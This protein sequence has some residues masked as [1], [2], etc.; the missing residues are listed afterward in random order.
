MFDFLATVSPGREVAWDCATGSGQAAIGLAGYFDR[1]IATDASAAQIDEAEAHPRIEYRVAPAHESGIESASIDL[2]T[3]AQAMHWLDPAAFYAEARRVTKRDG[4]VAIWGYGDPVFDDP[5]VHGVVH[6]YNRGTIERYWKPERHLLLDGYMTIPFPFSEIACPHFDL[7]VSW[8]LAEL[9]GYLRTWSATVAFAKEIGRD[10]VVD[11]EKE[12][13][14][15]WGKK[16]ERH[17]LRW[18]LFLRAGTV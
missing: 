6:A 1:V 16:E 15:H 17:Q 13:A 5:N 3:V 7:E 12:L 8:N 14:R 9:T 10:P 4:V 11:L 2:T 18:P